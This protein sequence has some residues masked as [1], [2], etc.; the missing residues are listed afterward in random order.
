M[1]TDSYMVNAKR[2]VLEDAWKFTRFLGGNLNGDWYVQRQWCLISGLDNPYPEMYDHPEIIPS[3]DRWID[4]KL[5]RE[6]YKKG[7][8]IAA[9]KEPW[10]GEYDTKAVASS[11]TSS[12]ARRRFPRA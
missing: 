10:Y 11:T 1:W 3:Y 6:Q 4:L 8:V 12:G 5:L 9:Y 7:K 2:K